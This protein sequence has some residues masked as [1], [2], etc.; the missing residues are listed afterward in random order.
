MDCRP[1]SGYDARHYRA[2]RWW[3][4]EQPSVFALAHG[5]STCSVD[6]K[7]CNRFCFGSHSTL[8]ELAV[9]LR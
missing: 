9:G 5:A 2:I 8:S 7:P 6:F 1:Y 4:V 3:S